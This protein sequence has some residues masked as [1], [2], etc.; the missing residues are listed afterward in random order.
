VQ[1]TQKEFLYKI[2]NRLRNKEKDDVIYFSP[3]KKKENCFEMMKSGKG[4]AH[5]ILITAD[6]CRKMAGHFSVVIS[7]FAVKNVFT[8]MTL[9]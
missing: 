2:R 9:E 8:T 1:L 5:T 3:K 4:E 7:F 6:F